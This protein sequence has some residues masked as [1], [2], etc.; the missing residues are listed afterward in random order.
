MPKKWSPGMRL[1]PWSGNND[2]TRACVF[3]QLENFYRAH[4][5]KLFL[6]DRH[7]P[8]LP[9]I[10]QEVL[11]KAKSGDVTKLREFVSWQL[12]PEFADFIQPKPQLN[13]GHPTSPLYDGSSDPKADYDNRSRVRMAKL[14]VPIIQKIWREHYDGKWTRRSGDI[15]AYEIAAQYFAIKEDDVRRKPSGRR[16][17]KPRAKN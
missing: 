17:K 5:D 8:L 9:L 6:E 15:D 12:G 2:A 11:A 4:R 1:P 3:Y 14:A 16:K 7:K 13:P 10:K